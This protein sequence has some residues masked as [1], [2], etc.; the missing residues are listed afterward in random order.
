MFL[1]F[2]KIFLFY[3][4]L[5]YKYKF[6][7]KE[8]KLIF[9]CFLKTLFRLKELRDVLVETDRTMAQVKDMFGDD[10]MVTFLKVALNFQFI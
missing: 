2:L 1:S 8:T 5:S 6:T 10:P 3:T 7:K 4:K 9:F